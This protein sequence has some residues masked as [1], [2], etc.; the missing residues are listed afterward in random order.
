MDAALTQMGTA[1]AASMDPADVATMVLDA[2]RTDTFYILPNSAPHI[3]ALEA[4]FAEL[5]ASARTAS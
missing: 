3:P 2:I 4:D 1:L 5:M